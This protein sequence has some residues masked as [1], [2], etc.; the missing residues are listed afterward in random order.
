[1]MTVRFLLTLLFLMSASLCAA[2]DEVLRD[3]IP[4][5]TITRFDE[6]IRFWVGG[7]DR[8]EGQYYI[9]TVVNEIQR[10]VPH[11]SITQTSSIGSANLRI[12]LTDS[13]QEWQEAILQATSDSA[14]WTEYGH[15][16]RGMTLVSHSPGG[17][18]RRADIILHLDFQTS[19]GQ[20]LWVVRH[21]FLHALGVLGHPTRTRSTV[22]NS[23]QPQEEKNGLFSDS[24]IL[25]LQ[26]I[27]RP[28]LKTGG[29]W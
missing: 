27:Y 10:I 15:L 7:K 8:L 23:R 21:E 16:I 25:V 28:D 19:G 3:Y 9:A 26:T 6:P 20:K 29:S 24:D 1:M 11:L 18:I 5:G 22:L 2:S 4:T 17:K 14:G 13:H 12:Y